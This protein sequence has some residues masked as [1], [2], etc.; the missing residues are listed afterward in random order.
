MCVSKY[1]RPL[2][3][4]CVR[5]KSY[6]SCVFFAE[7]HFFAPPKLN[8]FFLLTRTQFFITILCVFFALCS[9]F[10]WILKLYKTLNDNDLFLAIYKNFFFIW[11]QRHTFC[12]QW[13]RNIHRLRAQP[14]SCSPKQCGQNVH[15][16]FFEAR[17]EGGYFEMKKALLVV[18]IAG[19]HLKI[20][21]LLNNFPKYINKCSKSTE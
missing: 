21:L 20:K 10:L 2:Q 6:K 7:H 4:Q 15:N 9:R 13:R 5:P 19:I 12:T 1:H 11:R 3:A 16:S 18:F 17:F 8:S 14:I